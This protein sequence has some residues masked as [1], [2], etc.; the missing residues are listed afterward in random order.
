M[1]KTLLATS[2]IAGASLFATAAHAASPELS[3]TGSLE[4]QYHFFDVNTTDAGS[5]VQKNGN[6]HA[7]SADNSSSE[8]QFDFSATADNGLTY[9]GRYD[10]RMINGGSTTAD[11]A[12]I[13]FTGGWGRVHIG[14]DDTYS[15]NAVIGGYAALTA[16]GGYDGDATRY[17]DTNGLVS[18][19]GPGTGGLAD[20]ESRI[21]YYSPNF[22]GFEFG[23]SFTP[24]DSEFTSTT[25]PGGYD[26]QVDV[27]VQWGGTFG[28]NVAVKL[29]AGARYAEGGENQEDLGAFETGGTVGFGGFTVGA[30]FGWEGDSGSNENLIDAGDAKIDDKYYMDF[31][32]GYSA[33]PLAVGAGVFYS[34]ADGET[35][36]GSATHETIIYSL[37]SQYTLAEG[38]AAFAELNYGEFDNDGLNTNSDGV[39][40]GS[41]VDNTGILVGTKISF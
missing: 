32:V 10:M 19:T 11:E 31:A 8:I 26:N 36:A 14:D 33:G 30:G 16:T 34:E 20:D 38:L 18:R 40:R 41:K 5:D 22:S 13:Y 3:I 17:W 27:G 2:A 25:N 29:T 21:V 12:Y 6:G 39:D 1:R 28:D 35:T 37:T 15:D 23:A 4:Y 9:G 24:D 7:L